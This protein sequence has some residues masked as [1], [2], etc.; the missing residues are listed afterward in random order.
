MQYFGVFES[1]ID[2]FDFVQRRLDPL[3]GL[4]LKSVEHV[5]DA[6]Q[7]DGIMS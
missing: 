4:F 2:L 5:N 3:P 1:R 6:A 7:S